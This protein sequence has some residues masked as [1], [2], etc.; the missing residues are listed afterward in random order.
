MMIKGQLPFSGMSL[1]E[2]RNTLFD[3]EM[4]R[5]RLKQ[6]QLI[7][8]TV[9]GEVIQKRGKGC[10]GS[11]VCP[12]NRCITNTRLAPFSLA[13]I[14]QATKVHKDPAIIQ[15]FNS[16]VPALF[17]LENQFLDHVNNLKNAIH[18]EAVISDN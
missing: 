14:L 13:S 4:M 3:L 15:R 16:L 5:G 12:Q 8:H 2:S 17:I 11:K 9:C 18:E 7:Q 1:T 10:L 6:S